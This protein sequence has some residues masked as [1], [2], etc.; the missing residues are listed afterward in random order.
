M[1][2]PLSEWDEGYILSL[3]KE[4]DEIER[5]GSKKLDLTAGANEND[6]LDEL[7]KQLSAFA[8]TGG[9]RLI[10][11]LKDDGTVDSGGVST[12]IKRGGTKEWL[13]RQI[14]GLTE[15]EILGFGVHEF[16]RK[17]VDSQIQAGKALYVVDVPDSDRAPHQ[18]KRDMKYYVRLGSQSSPARHIMIEDIRNRQ[19]HPRVYPSEFKIENLVARPTENRVFDVDTILR[20]VLSNDGPLKSTDTFLQIKPVQ[21]HFR[22]SADPQTVKPVFGTKTGWY[23]WSLIEALPPESDI[24]FRVQYFFKAKVEMHPTSG[25]FWMDPAGESV[26]DLEIEWIIFADSAPPKKGT[27]KMSTIG[28]A[29]HLREKVG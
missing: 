3:P 8:N 11:G 15:Y 22:Y 16:E 10:Y 12:Q 2:K 23:Q 14:P 9:G 6:V 19:K 28:L 26:D 1:S 24:N 7:A 20:I 27:L 21:G 25:S 18:S 17:S 4:N 29:N 13:E 5:K